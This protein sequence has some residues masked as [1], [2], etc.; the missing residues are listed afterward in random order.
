MADISRSSIDATESPD[1]SIQILIA[2]DDPVVLTNLSQGLRL[3]GF[4]TIHASDGGS[5]L[6]ICLRTPP[7]IA[8]LD[9]AMPTLSAA[10]VAE[11][12]PP[13]SRI[14]LIFLSVNGDA[15][16]VRRAIDA[17]AMACLMKPID[18]SRLVPVIWSVLHGFSV[19][20]ALRAEAAK[21][22]TALHSARTISVAVGIVMERLRLTEMDAFECLR[23]YARS[24]N[25][26][27]A[28]V[29]SAILEHS[30]EFNQ[31]LSALDTTRRNL[32]RAV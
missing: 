12:L 31:M 27:V 4:S 18:P 21:L 22:T 28:D 13:V 25:A 14:P 1:N 9:Y 20:N 32:R 23:H 29:A 11:R 7:T 26:K 10:E 15:N 17:G 3:A 5:A 2:D 16:T 8:I 30:S 24:T 6:D 19:L